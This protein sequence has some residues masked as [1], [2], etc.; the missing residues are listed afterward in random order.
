MSNQQEKQKPQLGMI[1][2]LKNLPELTLPPEYELRHYEPGDES[3]WKRIISASFKKEDIDFQKMMRTDY[4]YR[5]ERILFITRNNIPVATASAW[6]RPKWGKNSGYLHMVG[7]LPDHSGKKLGF[8]VSLAALYH[9]MREGK[10]EAVLH[11]DDFRIPALKTYLKLGF[12]PL[13]FH[14]NHRE[15]WPKIFDKIGKPG[16]KDEFSDLL[17]GP[18]FEPMEEKPDSDSPDKYRFCHKWYT[19]RPH[20]LGTGNTDSLGDESLYK[21]SLLGTARVKPETIEAA[22]KASLKLIY[23]AGT[24]G[25]REGSRIIFYMGGQRPL[26]G[27]IQDI[28]IE[29]NFD[30]IFNRIKLEPVH[31]Q[32]P[33]SV[34]L[35]VSD[36]TAK[37]VVVSLKKGNLKKGDTIIVDAGPDSGFPWTPLAGRYEIKVIF[38]T[39]DNIPQ[40][41]LPE[42]LVIEVL[43]TQEDHL[44]TTVSCTHG[45][46]ESLKVHTTLRDKFDNRVPLDGTVELSSGDRKKSVPMKNGLCETF[47]KNENLT[48]FNIQAVHKESKLRCSSNPSIPTKGMNL[49]IGDLHVHDFMS[50]AH[51]YTDDI[52][53]WAKEDRNFDFVSIPVQLHG[54]LDNEKWTIAKFMNERFL[55]EGNFVTFLANEWQ[56][57]GYADKV[58]HFLGGDQPY[59]CVDDNRYSN[60]AKLYEAVRGSDALIISHH[61]SYPPGSWCSRTDF[62]VIETD[63]ERLVELWS[64]HGSSEGFDTQDRPLRKMD[65]DNTVLAALRRGLRVGFVGGSDTHSGRPGGSAKEPYP[66]WGGIAAVWAKSLTRRDLFEALYARRTYALTGAR[67]VLRMTVNG[68]PMGSELPATD[69]VDIA[70]DVWAP[71]R[72]KSVQIMKNGMLYDEHRGTG[73]EFHL[74]RDDTAGGTAFYH[75]RVQQE[76]GHLAVCSP[77]WIG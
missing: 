16:L 59:F 64:M 7:V 12:S 50:A 54:W 41:R 6:Y 36:K 15:R 29:D 27:G 23:T 49:Y 43:P 32:G 3:A 38:D 2:K 31:V 56:H 44:E 11:T 73:K 39:G 1:R 24:A 72:I 47:W 70:I 40:R 51:G 28:S 21:P 18:L 61:C 14:E 62:E 33:S 74:E 25:I 52:Y 10:K 53:R 55:D 71:E 35:E 46:T 37:Q 9:M 75:C 19:E 17:S 77:V 26:V 30:M 65:P 63:V 48:S 60:A 69:R 68:S 45:T 4:P 67:I 20:K 13:L 5:P 57:T 76:D 66:Y 8:M 58:I 42:P 22:A 34:D